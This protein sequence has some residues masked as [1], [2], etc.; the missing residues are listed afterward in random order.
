MKKSIPNFRFF[1][2]Y[3]FLE[4][5]ITCSCLTP[6]SGRLEMVEKALLFLCWATLLPGTFG[7]RWFLTAGEE[8]GFYCKENFTSLLAR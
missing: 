8:L 3:S 5:N 7:E 4:E 6:G 2:V 1:K